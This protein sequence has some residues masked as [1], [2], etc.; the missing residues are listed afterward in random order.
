MVVAVIK[1]GL[2]NQLFIYAAAYSFAEKYNLPLY[3]D[4]DTGFLN[5]KYKRTFDINN[6]N[7][8]TDC[9]PFWKSILL[10][11]VGKKWVHRFFLFFLNK[12]T[13]IIN[14]DEKNF[15]QDF[16]PDKTIFRLEDYFQAER[17]FSN[18][19]SEIKTIISSLSLSDKYSTLIKLL[20]QKT[21]LV[22]HGRLLRAFASDGT[23]VVNE[24]LDAKQLSNNFFAEAVDKF[25][26][27]SHISDLVI[28]SDNP[29]AFIKILDHLNLN[30]HTVDKVS[31]GNVAEELT[32]MSYG[33]N[34]VI[35][36]STFSWWGAYL[37]KFAEKKVLIPESQYWESETPEYWETI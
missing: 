33:R 11:A 24:A 6:F 36:N 4:I 17:Y 8:D 1:G 3:L 27:H 20:A 5:D 29:Q 28:F 31:M 13:K 37:S 35:S 7:I 9:L 34:F 2:G 18:Q 22:V 21:T 32:L 23:Q 26:I 30:I 14:I 12:N 16:Y 15:F 19:K 25:L 10:K